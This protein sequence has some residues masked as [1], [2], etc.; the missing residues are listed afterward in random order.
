MSLTVHDV[1]M[2]TNTHGHIG[3]RGADPGGILSSGTGAVILEAM[4]LGL[5]RLASC[6]T[7]DYHVSCPVN[8]RVYYLTKKGWAHKINNGTD[9]LRDYQ[10][11]FMSEYLVGHSEI[12]GKYV[13]YT[14]AQFVQWEEMLAHRE[15]GRLIPTTMVR[16]NVGRGDTSNYLG[17][18]YA[19]PDQEV[20]AVVMTSDNKW[21]TYP[22]Y[23]DD[24]GIT[25]FGRVLMYIAAFLVGAFLTAWLT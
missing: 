4:R 18:D 9:L 17:V 20:T 24:K 5:L 1:I 3:L 11:E 25:P 6:W 19:Q 8:R 23:R 21:H 2:S 7:H 13:R 15:V 14:E 12:C 10:T 22:P 16:A